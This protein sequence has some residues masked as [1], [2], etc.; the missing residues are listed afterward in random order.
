MREMAQRE[1]AITTQVGE[2]VSPMRSILLQEVNL[3]RLLLQIFNVSC[4]HCSVVDLA[5]DFTLF[6]SLVSCKLTCWL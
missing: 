4:N 3:L 5:L 6:V 1:E 2:F